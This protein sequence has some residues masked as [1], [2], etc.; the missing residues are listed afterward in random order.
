MADCTYAFDFAE[1]L[2][3]DFFLPQTDVTWDSVFSPLTAPESE[4]DNRVPGTVSR[5][6]LCQELNLFQGDGGRGRLLDRCLK[7]L[8]SIP[9]TSVQ[10]ERDFSVVSHINHAT[11]V[12]AS[13]LV[14]V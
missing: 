3:I 9:Q 11:V 10:P 14:F 13:D 12:S 1:Q 2:L 8:S 7:V 4:A 6:T 5:T